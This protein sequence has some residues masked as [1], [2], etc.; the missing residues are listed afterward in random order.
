MSAAGVPLAA[1]FARILIV[2]DEPLT[3]LYI[4]ELLKSTGANILTAGQ[5][6]AACKLAA[7]P[8]LCAAVVEPCS[9]HKQ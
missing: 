8:N 9:Q 3:A 6:P 4:V 7:D 2:E 5:L 1:G